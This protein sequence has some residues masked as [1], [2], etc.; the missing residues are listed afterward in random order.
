MWRSVGRLLTARI[1]LAVGCATA[2]VIV[3][4]PPRLDLGIMLAVSSILGFVE[5]RGVVRWACSDPS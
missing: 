2:V 3:S 4:A 5:H 1:V